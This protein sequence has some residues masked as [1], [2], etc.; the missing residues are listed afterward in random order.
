MRLRHN[1]N[2]ILDLPPLAHDGNRE[3]DICGPVG[4]DAVHG[5]DAVA[6]G[7]VRVVPEAAADAAVLALFEG[8]GVVGSA[9]GVDCVLGAGTGAPDYLLAWDEVFFWRGL[10]QREGCWY[11]GGGGGGVW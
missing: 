1:P 4:A 3:G 10:F 2:R 8:E 6:A 11:L 5:G 9:G 7:A